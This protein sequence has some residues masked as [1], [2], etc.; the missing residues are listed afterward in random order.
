MMNHG[1]KALM[2]LDDKHEAHIITKQ[3]LLMAFAD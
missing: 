1:D 2:V 3:D